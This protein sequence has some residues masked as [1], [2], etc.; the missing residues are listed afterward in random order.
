[1]T[2]QATSPCPGCRVVLPV[3]REEPEARRM[4]SAACWGRH[5]D[6]VGFEL[7]HAS[8]V[9][10]FHQLTVDAYGAQ[11]PDPPTPRIR[12]FYSLVGLHLALDRGLT[13]V[14]VREFHQ[15]MGKP[16]AWW[17]ELAPPGERGRLTVDDVARAGVDAGSVD[18][19]AEAVTR[20]ATEVW[21]AWRGCHAEI[22]T[23]TR[24]LLDLRGG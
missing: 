14:Q 6:V 10:P 17:P 2:V 3:R 8:L 20:W 15:R 21:A 5:N 11:H 23:F 13:G 19:H 9:A 7:S 4:A 24:R 1:M 22:A 18:G 16:A 12:V